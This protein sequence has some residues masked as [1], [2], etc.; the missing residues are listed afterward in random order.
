MYRN[1][2]RKMLDEYVWRDGPHEGRPARS[3]NTFTPSV[4]NTSKPG[5]RDAK[6]DFLSSILTIAYNHC[7]ANRLRLLAHL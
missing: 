5:I 4:R 7:E 1:Q 6:S 3:S 2:N